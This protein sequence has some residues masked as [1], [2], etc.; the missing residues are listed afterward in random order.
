MRL[1]V[2]V[3]ENF[4]TY[5]VISDLISTIID[6]SKSLSVIAHMDMGWIPYLLFFVQKFM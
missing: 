6:N 5:L 1:V 2:E 3:C 4:S